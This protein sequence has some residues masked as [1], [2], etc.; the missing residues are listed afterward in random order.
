MYWAFPFSEGSLPLPIN[1]GLTRL[2]IGPYCQYSPQEIVIAVA[3]SKIIVLHGEFKTQS[4][5]SLV[6][7]AHSYVTETIKFCEY[8]TSLLRHTSSYACKIM[9]RDL[10]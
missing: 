8:D 10:T 3:P 7:S 2:L 9:Q 4:L 1:M 6:Y 5:Y